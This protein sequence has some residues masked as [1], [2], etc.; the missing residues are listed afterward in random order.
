MCLDLAFSWI[1]HTVLWFIALTSAVCLVDVKQ[2]SKWKCVK[3]GLEKR[4]LY[5]SMNREYLP[6]QVSEFL[7]KKRVKSVQLQCKIAYCYCHK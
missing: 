3:E 6:S 2:E 1:N 4:G 5:G 7:K